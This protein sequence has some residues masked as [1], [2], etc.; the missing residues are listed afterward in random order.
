[1]KNNQK[2]REQKNH[3]SKD[4][5]ESPLGRYRSLAVCCLGLVAK[6]E[7]KSI[8]ELPQPLLDS[9]GVS[10]S[11]DKMHCTTLKVKVPDALKNGGLEQRIGELE[12][13]LAKHQDHIPPQTGFSRRKR[14]FK[15]LWPKRRKELEAKRR[16][17]G[18]EIT[19][20]MD[21]LAEDTADPC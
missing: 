6:I 12:S 21:L 9:L 16:A 20:N 4:K 19:T 17:E 1:M 7:K 15:N 18:N 2:K 5:D 8:K 10:L 11:T 3:D 13:F 14:S